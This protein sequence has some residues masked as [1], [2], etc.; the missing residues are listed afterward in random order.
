MLEMM[1]GSRQTKRRQV[2][3]V[4][5]AQM[6]RLPRPLARRFARLMT[7]LGTM[8]PEAPQAAKNRL[9]GQFHQLVREIEQLPNAREI[10]AKPTEAELAEVSA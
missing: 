3:G 10:F 6:G 2:T 8:V 7:K 4:L 1:E 9:E 5:M